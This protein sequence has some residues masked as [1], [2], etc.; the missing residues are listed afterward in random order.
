MYNGGLRLASCVA[1]VSLQ[2]KFEP[3]RDDAMSAKKLVIKNIGQILSGAL[4]EPI[5]DGDC[6]VAIDGKIHAWGAEKELDLW[7]QMA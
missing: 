5:Y 1:H 3:V 6:I 2:T 7:M 4:E